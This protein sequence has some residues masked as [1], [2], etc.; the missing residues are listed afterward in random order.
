[1][2]WKAGKV[3]FLWSILRTHIYRLCEHKIYEIKQTG[4]LPNSHWQGNHIV[5]DKRVKF[6]NNSKFERNNNV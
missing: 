5:F 6:F 1:M 2:S 3:G 4:N